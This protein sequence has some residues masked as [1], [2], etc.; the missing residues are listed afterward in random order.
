MEK[1][2]ESASKVSRREALPLQTEIGALDRELKRKKKIL[3]HNRSK[4]EFNRLV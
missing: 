4:Q 1:P 3:P 2:A